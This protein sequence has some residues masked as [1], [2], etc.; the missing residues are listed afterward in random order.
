MVIE[1]LEEELEDV[2]LAK[3]EE[4]EQAELQRKVIEKTVKFT[5]EARKQ[6]GNL[7]KAVAI[8]GSAAKGTMK[9]GSDA[10][11]WVILDDTV[12]KSSED[13]N[14]VSSQLYLIAHEL[15]DLHIQITFLTEFWQLMKAGSPELVNFLRYSLLI[16]DTGFLKPV[17]RMLQLG[18]IP[19]S[20]ETISLKAK[21]AEARYEKVKI[22]MKS[23]IFDLRYAATDVIQAVVMYYYKA[24]P[25]QKSIPEF[26]EKLVKEKKLEEEY[27]E[28]FKELDKLWKDIEHKIVKDVD[29]TYLDKALKLAREIIDRFKILLPEEFKPEIGEIGEGGE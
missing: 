6:Y 26:L 12:T 19:P 22:D 1:N 9:K 2:E 24:Q 5:N 23:M 27:I 21:T 15:K 3:K 8:F 16:Y 17:Q 28:K 13:L 18:L 29:A 7:I 25:D 4:Q 11:V 20:E 14:K 10:D